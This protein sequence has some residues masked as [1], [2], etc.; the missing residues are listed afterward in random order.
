[1][2]FYTSQMALRTPQMVPQIRHKGARVQGRNGTMVQGR[3]S[4]GKTICFPTM[5]VFEQKETFITLEFCKN[6]KDKNY[7]E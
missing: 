5:K 2:A 6:V 3:K 7:L 1:M 4:V